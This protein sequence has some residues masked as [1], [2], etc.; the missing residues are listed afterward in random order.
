[1]KDV[2]V[3]RMI[4]GIGNPMPVKAE[5]EGF[6]P[7]YRQKP[8]NWFRVSPVTATSVRLLESVINS[9]EYF[10]RKT[11]SWQGARGKFCLWFFLE[12]LPNYYQSTTKK[13]YG[14]VLVPLFGISSIS[15]TFG[16]TRYHSV[17]AFGSL[18]GKFAKR[19]HLAA[20]LRSFGRKAGKRYHLVALMRFF[21]VKP[22]K[23]Y[24]HTSRARS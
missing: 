14:M 15:W 12:L 21:D 23:R 1:M 11:V 22:A 9:V 19:Y 8:I 2:F 20:T 5:T 3:I 24:H 13:Q 18:E 17:A 7:S 16:N 10:I 4:T 6:E